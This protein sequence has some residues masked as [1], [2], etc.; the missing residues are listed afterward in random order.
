ME[1]RR[2]R[3]Q[4]QRL[5]EKQESGKGGSTATI[6]RVEAKA[7]QENWDSEEGSTPTIEREE[8]QRLYT[9]TGIPRGAVR[10]Q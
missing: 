9:K 6:D 2:Q 7:I 4:R 10:R 8:K 5:Y 1:G 3:E